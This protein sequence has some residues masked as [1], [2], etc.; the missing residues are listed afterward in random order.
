MASGDIARLTDDRNH[1]SNP[2][3]SPDGRSLL[4]DANMRTDASRAMIPNLMLVDL[5]GEQSTVLADWANMESASFTPDGIADRL[6][7]ATG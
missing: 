5:S 4:Y 1:N 6:C 7:R 2:R 3:W